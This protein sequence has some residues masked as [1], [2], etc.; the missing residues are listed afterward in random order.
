[1]KNN[2]RTIWSVLFT[3]FQYIAGVKSLLIG[4]V[5][6]LALATAGYLCNVCFDGVLDIHYGSKNATPPFWEHLALV[7]GS[8]LMVSLVMY[9]TALILKSKARIVDMFG[10]LAM[11]KTPYLL[12]ALMGLIPSL[13]PDMG[14]RSDVMN[15]TMAEM[16]SMAGDMMIPALLSSLIVLPL[17]VWYVVLM[18]NGYSVS[19]NLKGAK[20]GV[21][22]T[23][24]LIFSEIVCIII[25]LSFL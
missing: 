10:T 9:L 23:I 16:Q 22:F 13:H 18:Y 2:K 4:I 25:N 8:W 6:L 1:M 20:G 7:F 12:A 5:V 17:I 24:A 14:S 21:S 19:S 15:M 11:A 3:P